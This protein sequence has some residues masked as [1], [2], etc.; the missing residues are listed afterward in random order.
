MPFAQARA[1]SVDYAIMEKVDNLSV[2]VHRGDWSDL[3]GWEAVR[4]HGAADAD[5]W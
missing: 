4:Q 2:A 5:C 3:G 1:I